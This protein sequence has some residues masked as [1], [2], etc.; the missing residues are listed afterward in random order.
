MN[1]VKWFRKNNTKVMAVVVIVIMVG[2]I[3]GSSLTYL[4][5]GSGGGNRAVAYY[6]QKR[7]ITPNNRAVARRELEILQ[8]LGAGRVLQS[9]DLRGLLLSEL[10]FSQERGSAELVNYARQAI[11]RNRYRISDKQL[12]EIYDR[13]VPT[14]IYWILLREEAQSAGFHVGPDDVGQLLGQVIPQLFN[15]S[16][17]AQAMQALVS[18]Y[19]LPETDILATFGR[20]LAVLQ[21]S[22]AACSAESVTDAEIKH[23]ASRENEVLTAACVQLKASFFQDVNSTPSV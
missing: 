7:K 9:Q 17:Y 11:Q 13:T 10:L 16:T 6:G 4:L 1:L 14:D 5:R 21:Y 19:G 23:L 15:G 12:S 2:F 22:E 20:L 8:S 3:G 18:R